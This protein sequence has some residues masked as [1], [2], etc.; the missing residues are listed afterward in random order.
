MTRL[1]KIDRRKALSLLLAGAMVTA[2]VMSMIV[3]RVTQA[4]VEGTMGGSFTTN[5]SSSAPLVNSVALTG[6]DNVA[7]T[8]MDPQTE[9]YIQVSVTDNQTLE[10]LTS[11][12][13][14]VYYDADGDHTPVLTS[15]DNETCAIITWTTP[16]TW[17]LSSMGAGSTWS[18][19]NGT[20]P[21]LTN[22]T[23][24]FVFHFTPGKVATENA[25]PAD[26]DI[27]VTATDAAAGEDV[28]SQTG[29]NMNWYGEISGVTATVDF[30]SV[31]LGTEDLSSALNAKYVS[32]GNYSEQA[33]TVSQWISGSYNVDLELTSTPGDGEF[34]LWVN[35]ES[36]SAAETQLTADYVDIDNNEVITTED[37]VTNAGMY[38]WL[39]LGSSGIHSGTYTGNI[40]FAIS[41]RA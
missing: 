7:A 18:I 36:N 21:T 13:A 10:H 32:N 1:A 28:E 29:R 37:G 24:T 19:T 26:W 14:T 5:D 23:G 12:Q 8:N 31:S 17:T 22:N 9:Y 30:G 35:D 27:S 11:V 20:T 2:T 33:K 16:N 25:A 39:T 15:V 41:N 38:L 4:A 3:P 40:Y 34:T 6:T